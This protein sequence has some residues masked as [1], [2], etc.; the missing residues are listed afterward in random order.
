M[1]SVFEKAQ[2]TCPTSPNQD[3]IP[4]IFSGLGKFKML[5]ISSSPGSTP[6]SVSWNPKYSTS[7]RPKTNLFLFMRIPPLPHIVKY[8]HVLKNSSSKLRS[9]RIESSTNLL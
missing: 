5:F 1:I 8:L 9:H 3:L 7:L 6:S 2:D 4:D